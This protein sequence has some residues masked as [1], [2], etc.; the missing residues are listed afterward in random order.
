VGDLMAMK[1]T[2]IASLNQLHATLDP[3]QRAKLVQLLEEHHAKHRARMEKGEGRFGKK[4]GKRLGITDAQ[5]RQ[6]RQLF[7]ASMTP[8]ERAEMKQRHEE[9]YQRHKAALEAFKSDTFD[10]AKLPIFNR[11]HPGHLKAERVV[12]FLNVAL[13]IFTPAQRAQMAQMIEAR[14][15]AFMESVKVELPTT[16]AR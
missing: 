14:S 3:D 6:L 4:L 11:P 12:R 5:R 13:P 16:T 9:R 1:P 15:K 7:L 10:A 2:F 8:Q